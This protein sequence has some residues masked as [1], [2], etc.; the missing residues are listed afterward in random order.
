M[1]HH[2]EVRTPCRLHFGLTSLGHD[3]TRPQFGGVGVMV[4]APG[5][6]L[7]ISPSHKFT[8]SGP[9]KD[10]V[11]QFAS[12]IFQ[13]WH[14]PASPEVEIEVISA[15]R[16]HVGLGVGTQLGLA[17]AAGLGEALGL[18][19]RDPQRL[20]Q[21]TRRGR[22]S[23]VGTY[24]FLQ[25]GLIV[26]GGHERGESL[27]HLVHRGDLPADWRFVLLLPKLS[28]GCAGS[29]E[30]RAFAELPAVPP[31]VTAELEHIAT[32]E[33][34]PAAQDADFNRFS[35][36]LY[37]YGCLAGKCFAAVQGG[38]FCSPQTAELI[39]RLREQDIAGVGQSSWGPTVFALMADQD[40]AEQLIR[41]FF[42]QPSASDYDVLIA[43][44][45][46]EG[47]IVESGDETGRSN[48]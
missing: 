36:G 31:A 32:A 27:G 10:R 1:N 11:E 42:S 29:A 45:T 47:A 22:R 23:A 16:E 37:R 3:P 48:T 44:P 35:D 18:P 26:D 9:L 38:T 13:H 15:P 34:I 8:A 12:S 24:G 30:E 28:T 41:D 39:A 17:V 21:L 25:G 5:V 20:A 14:M 6:C 19:W 43:T 33:L 4:D 40:S 7:R 2:V 46:N